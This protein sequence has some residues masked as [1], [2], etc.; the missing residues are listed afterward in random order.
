MR[1]TRISR[2]G[3]CAFLLLA[4]VT[5]VCEAGP[6]AAEIETIHSLEPQFET[7]HTTWA[8]PYARGT[9]RALFVLQMGS[10]SNSL[11]L[12]VAVEL[13]QRF[14]I[15]G[16]AVL[17]SVQGVYGE[18]PGENRLARLLESPYDCYIVTG[19]SMGQIPDKARGAI[20]ASVKRG[21]G[22]FFTSKPEGGLPAGMQPRENPPSVL[23]GIN[24]DFLGMGKGRVVLYTHPTGLNLYGP[25]PE[26]SIFGVDLLRDEHYERM[27]RTIMWAARREPQLQLSISV[28]ADPIDRH[29]LSKHII[30]V[31]LK[32]GDFRAGL[33]HLKSRIRSQS[34]GSQPFSSSVVVR[35]GESGKTIEI[36]SL[37]AEHEEVTARACFSRTCG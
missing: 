7:P 1:R 33:P 14:D 30:R 5:G 32:G 9:V 20:L 16:D 2:T 27:G 37:S 11:P 4:A 10:N 31:G 19:E 8:K 22:L 25:T 28:P 29:E 23:S 36:P 12:R 24:A 35:S 3:S 17:T 13:M 34:N 6:S 15:E 18:E 21:A 26:Q